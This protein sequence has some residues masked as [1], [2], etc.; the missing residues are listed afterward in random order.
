MK[1]T[2]ANQIEFFL[3]VS[4]IEK[5]GMARDFWDERSY[6]SYTTMQPNVESKVSGSSLWHHSSSF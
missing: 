4:W 3:M 6:A 2:Q 5:D 1:K